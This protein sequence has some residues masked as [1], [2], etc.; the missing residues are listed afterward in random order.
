MT[1]PEWT[2]SH[3]LLTAEKHLYCLSLLIFRFG[4]TCR[5]M[6]S[7]MPSQA[8]IDSWQ[9]WKRNPS[10]CHALLSQPSIWLVCSIRNCNRS[11]AKTTWLSFRSP[12]IWSTFRNQDAHRQIFWGCVQSW[13]PSWKWILARVRNNP[14]L[15]WP[16]WG[17]CSMSAGPPPPIWAWICSRKTIFLISFCISWKFWHAIR[18]HCNTDRQRS[19]WHFWLPIFNK[20]LP[21]NRDIRQPSWVSFLN[22]KNTAT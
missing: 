19:L 18:W 15:P 1:S 13:P 4:M 22:S 21:G 11:K 3:L 10:T 12:W 5:P 16:C 14:S 17:W 8:L 2:L 20:E 9:R 7:S 6:C